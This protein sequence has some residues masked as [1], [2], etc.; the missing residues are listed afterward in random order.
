MMTIMSLVFGMS[1]GNEIF[2]GEKP[3]GDTVS[4]LQYYFLWVFVVVVL[5]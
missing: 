2:Q 5:I 1:I 3:F 4:N